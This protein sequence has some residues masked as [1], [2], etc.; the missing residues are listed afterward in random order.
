MA[1]SKATGTAKNMAY[2]VPLSDPIIT[3]TSDSFGS[4]SSE[5]PVDCQTYLGS[6]APS[7][8]ILPNTAWETVKGRVFC[9]RTAVVV[10][11]R[12]LA[13]VPLPV[14]KALLRKLAA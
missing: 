5:P 6:V 10:A 12:R 8:Q 9:Q 2:S 14:R 11:Y 13:R 7:Y 4:K 1:A 3:G